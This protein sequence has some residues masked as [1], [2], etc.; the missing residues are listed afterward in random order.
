M[1][2]KANGLTSSGRPNPAGAVDAPIVSVF[3]IVRRGRRA[4]DQ[5]RY[6]K[7]LF[8]AFRALYGLLLLS[9]VTVCLA[10]QKDRQPSSLPQPATGIFESEDKFDGHPL[11][12]LHL[13][14]NGTYQV[15]CNQPEYV[16]GI[17]GGGLFSYQ[18]KESG[19]W[20]WEP[21]SHQIV[22]KATKASHMA[23]WFPH[24]F[25]IPEDESVRLEAVNPPPQGPQNGRPLWLPL[26]S[27]YFH[28]KVA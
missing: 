11:F 5:R 9:L 14:T 17:D 19:T 8:P 27:P 25:K 24:V 22:L 26:V 13:E 3:H 21:Q 20:R 10:Q 18:G 15:Q 4:T 1:K 28:R 16:Q 7:T 2:S 23:Q 12:I 6:M